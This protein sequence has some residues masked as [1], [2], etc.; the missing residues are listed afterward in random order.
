MQH[1]ELPSWVPVARAII[2]W[3][4]SSRGSGKQAMRA[5]KDEESYEADE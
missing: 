1:I 2:R 4:G 5:R 3:T